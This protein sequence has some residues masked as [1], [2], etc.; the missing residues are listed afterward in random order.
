MD[1]GRY[2]DYDLT[3]I[4]EVPERG[5][6]VLTGKDRHAN[7]A[8]RASETAVPA[9][10]WSAVGTSACIHALEQATKYGA[11]TVAVMAPSL[12]VRDQL[13]GKLAPPSDKLLP[14]EKDLFDRFRRLRKDFDQ[15]FVGYAGDL[16]H[17]APDP[18]VDAAAYD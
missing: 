12:T 17:Q 3:V 1:D 4:V 11:R 16:T 10:S 7:T 18:L 9:L 6:F 8:F 14:V 5:R 15:V 13:G 2:A